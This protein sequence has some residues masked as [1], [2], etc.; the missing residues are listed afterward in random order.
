MYPQ[1]SLKVDPATGSVAIRTQFP[2]DGSFSD[3]AWLIATSSK[4]ARTASSEALADWV[5]IP[6]ELLT[7]LIEGASNG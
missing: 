4:G 6:A 5:D 7:A 2:D 3:M 1:S